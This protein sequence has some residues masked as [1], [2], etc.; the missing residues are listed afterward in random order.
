MNYR[1][2]PGKMEMNFLLLMITLRDFL[3]L[4]RPIFP[5]ILLLIFR[6]HTMCRLAHSPLFLFQLQYRSRG[7]LSR[8]H[9]ALLSLLILVLY[10]VPVGGP[11]QLGELPLGELQLGDSQLGELQL[12]ECQL[13]ESSLE[14]CQF[15][16]SQLGACDDLCDE[17]KIPAPPPGLPVRDGDIPMDTMPSSLRSSSPPAPYSL[18]DWDA[19]MTRGMGQLLRDP[20]SSS[21]VPVVSKHLAPI[22]TSVPWPPYPSFAEHN[23]APPLPLTMIGDPTPVPMT[24]ATRQRWS[25]EPI[26]SPDSSIGDR[27][28]D[29]AKF[30]S[31]FEPLTTRRRISL[32]LPSMDHPDSLSSLP[33]P[34][35]VRFTEPLSMPGFF[36]HYVKYEAAVS[37]QPQPQKQ[38]SFLPEDIS[39][40]TLV[41]TL[42]LV[43]RQSWMLEGDLQTDHDADLD[44][45]RGNQLLF[46]DTSNFVILVYQSSHYH[47]DVL[48][49]APVS[50][51][52]DA[53]ASTF[54]L[55]PT[56]IVLVTGGRYLSPTGYL[57]DLPPVPCGSHV[58]VHVPTCH[59]SLDSVSSLGQFADLIF[60]LHIPM[61]LIL[62][63]LSQTHPLRLQISAVTKQLLFYKAYEMFRLLLR[64]NPCNRALT[65]I[66]SSSGVS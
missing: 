23:S 38:V 17:D 14:Q 9:L 21:S 36:P 55:D 31:F 42:T 25:Y 56:R 1:F 28:A 10:P 34:K 41:P 15:G 53:A 40:G 48:S 52:M 59:D 4:R 35:R 33:S 20:R 29:G 22:V 18:H 39:P 57:S 11:P 16:E 13:G 65:S 43:P 58:H 51:I 60:L 26:L 46:P 64:P 2:T 19:D 45:H 7:R 24:N 63:R 32:A 37:I 6:R 44:W 50:R 66:R 27:R 12:E 47:C 61:Q 5:V 54:A 3:S 62:V 30:K 8:N 49:T